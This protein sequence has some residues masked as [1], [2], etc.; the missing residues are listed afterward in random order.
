MKK[1]IKN[2]IILMVILCIVSC[3]IGVTAASIYYA[4]DIS[5]TP[6]DSSWEVSNV[7]E[8]LNDLY[9][10]ENDDTAEIIETG[11]VSQYLA[12][13]SSKSVKFTFKNNYIDEDNAHILITNVSISGGTPAPYFNQY[14]LRKEIIGNYTEIT[15]YNA[16]GT[17]AG[18]GTITINYAVVKLKEI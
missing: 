5:Y 7:S 9:I 1:I 2:K 12:H 15:L 8:A 3:G 18:D 16:A 11:T 4:T 13:S 6:T 17:T 10:L 14:G